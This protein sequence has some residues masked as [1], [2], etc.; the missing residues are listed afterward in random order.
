MIRIQKTSLDQPAG[1]TR[2]QSD[3]KFGY[4]QDIENKNKS[5]KFDC[6][7]KILTMIFL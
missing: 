7:G 1:P 2:K 5:H 6:S 3:L 4:R